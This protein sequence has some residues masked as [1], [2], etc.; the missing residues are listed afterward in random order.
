MKNKE[1]AKQGNLL[2]QSNR[3]IEGRYTMTKNET[4][5]L[6]SMLSILNQK[7]ASFSE[8]KL[9]VKEVRKALGLGKNQIVRNITRIT[10]RLMSRII[11]INTV[12][13]WQKFNWLSKARLEGDSLTMMFHDDIK[14]YLLNMKGDFTKF[15]LSEVVGFESPNTLRLY[16]LIKSKKSQRKNEFTIEVDE[17]DAMIRGSDTKQGVLFSSFNARVLTPIK[18][19]LSQKIGD[20]Y[21]H[22]LSFTYETIKTGRRITSI[23]FTVINQ[24]LKQEIEGDTVKD[25]LRSIGINTEQATKL[26][27][28]YGEN[29]VLLRLNMLALSCV[30]TDIRNKG[31]FIVRALENGWKSN[32]EHAQNRKD[33]ELAKEAKERKKRE[34]KLQQK[35]SKNLSESEI[36]ELGVRFGKQRREEFIS[37]LSASEIQA[38]IDTLIIGADSLIV[39]S[40]KNNGIYSP[41]LASEVNKMIP[42]FDS[43]RN[44]FISENKTSH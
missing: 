27:K 5:L 8:I 38:M 7:S 44:L 40:V 12:N 30:H 42:D 4:L 43:D 9:P 15:R 19:E 13:G 23:K 18:K 25:K 32:E 31:G 11:T 33:E 41:F 2:Y 1:Y 16:Q 20:Y 24:E 17:L 26:I 21:K 28:V 3:I 36:K 34:N 22:A 29:E 39:T 6:L 14:P 37:S 35:T 10:D